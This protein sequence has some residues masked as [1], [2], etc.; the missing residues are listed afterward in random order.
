MEKNEFFLL[1]YTNMA[2]KRG[3]NKSKVGFSLDSDLLEDF[4][5]YC[6]KHTVNKSKLVNKL[7]SDFLKNEVR[8]KSKV[9]SYEG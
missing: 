8:E 1:I 6:E 5:E 3:I 2:R 9:M 4:N 7:I